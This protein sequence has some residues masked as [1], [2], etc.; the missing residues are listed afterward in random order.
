MLQIT[1]VIPK[2]DPQ[3]QHLFGEK[4]YYGQVVELNYKGELIDAEAWPRVLA[5]KFNKPD[6]APVFLDQEMPADYNPL[7]P[8]LPNAPG[9]VIDPEILP[10]YSQQDLP[11][12]PADLPSDDATPLPV[13]PE[14]QNL[15]QH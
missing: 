7:N 8:L 14:Y 15:P 13:P 6:A 2:I 9:N 3:Q 10:D 5:R 1:Y 4:R 11:P 12:P